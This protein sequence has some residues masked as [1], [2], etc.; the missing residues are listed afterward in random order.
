MEFGE[1]SRITSFMTVA[2][3]HACEDSKIWSLVWSNRYIDRVIL[4]FELRARD[5][6]FESKMAGGLGLNGLFVY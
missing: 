2:I 4:E 1:I 5:M 3:L 6:N